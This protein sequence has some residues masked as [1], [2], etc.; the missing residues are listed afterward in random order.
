MAILY[1]TTQQLVDA[2]LT[3][4]T[5]K[6]QALVFPYVIDHVVRATAPVEERATRSLINFF[7]SAATGFLAR[8]DSNQTWLHD[9]AQNEAAIVQEQLAFIARRAMPQGLFRITRYDDGTPDVHIHLAFRSMA[10]RQTFLDAYT[11]SLAMSQHIGPANDPF[12]QL[13]PIHNQKPLSLLHTST[14]PEGIWLTPPRYQ[15]PAAS[16]TTT[17]TAQPLSAKVANAP[18]VRPMAKVTHLF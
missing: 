17:A 11:F 4:A 2:A 16:F 6:A 5:S 12:F 8:T 10:A 3:P 7:A 9:A 13:R 14:E 15:P 1:T 18:Y